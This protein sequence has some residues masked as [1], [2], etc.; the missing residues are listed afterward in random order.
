MIRAGDNGKKIKMRNILISPYWPAMLPSMSWQ[1]RDMRVPSGPTNLPY[2][3]FGNYSSHSSTSLDGV[4]VALRA[5]LSEVC[6]SIDADH[7][8]QMVEKLTT[9]SFRDAIKGFTAALVV[10][11]PNAEFWWDYMT[12]VSILLCFTRAQRDGSWDLH[13]YAF[14]RMLPFLFRYDHVNYAIWVTVYLAEMSVIP[15]EV[16]HELQEGNFVVKRADR[17][18]NQV[19][20]DQSTEWLNAIGKKSGGLVGI[21]RVASAL[22]RWTLSYNLRTVIASQTTTMLRL[23][24]DD[25]DDEY[26]H[27]EC[28]KGRM[29][30]DDIDEGNIVV[31]LKLH[32]VFQDGGDTL[33]NLINKDVVTPQIQ[34][35]LL[36]A[37]HLVEEQMIIFVDKRLCEP[38]DSERHL[39]LKAP[40]Q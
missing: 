10:E 12:M 22:S 20:A 36:S 15:P 6:T 31:S 5:V 35:S 17:R 30:K 21:T 24:T 4:D 16:L 40:I 29:E 19:S 39:N 2:R 27:N 38:P 25:E 32:G 34:E 26:T 8:A 23:T 13:L 11:N 9:D 3:L 33:K 18:F 37:E 1:E 7:I 14:K 28:T